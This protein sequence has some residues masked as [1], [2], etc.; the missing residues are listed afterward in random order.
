MKSVICILP[1]RRHKQS[2]KVDLDLRPRNFKS[3]GVLFPYVI[4]MRV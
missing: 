2:V 3:I 4:Y 1:E